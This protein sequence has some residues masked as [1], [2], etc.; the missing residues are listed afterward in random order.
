MQ[1][2]SHRG[3]HLGAAGIHENTHAAFERA[4]QFD[5]DGIETDIRLSADAQPIL[6][7]DRLAPDERPVEI[8]TRR[9]LAEIVGYEIPTLAEILA[10]FPDVFWN[11]EVKSE[12]AVPATIGL[13]QRHPRPDRLLLTSF[14]HHIVRE[15]ADRLDVACGLL[16]AHA[17][18]DVTQMLG[19]WQALP[20]M[21]TIVWDFNVLDAG[22]VSQAKQ[23]GLLVYAYGMT[24]P[25]EHRLCQAWQLDGMITDFPDRA[26]PSS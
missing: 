4:I 24:T 26:R 2:L 19:G 5:V 12:A 21:R 22:I 20:R 15:C 14:R 7:H 25:H 18:I 8:L 3:F 16:V 9:E 11:L 10:R 13:V 17:P 1:I 6:F 23:A